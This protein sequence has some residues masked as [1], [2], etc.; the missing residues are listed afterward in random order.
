MLPNGAYIISVEAG[1]PAEKAGLLPGDILVELNGNVIA[2][3]DAMIAALEDT[4]AGDVITVTV[5]RPDT[6]YDA[7]R[8]SFSYDGQYV[9]NIQVTL[10]ILEEAS[11]T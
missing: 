2:T 4:K 7:E 10:A 1:S 6:V 11:N 3:S 5:W 8:G 9:E